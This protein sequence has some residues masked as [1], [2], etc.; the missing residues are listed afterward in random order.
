MPVEDTEEHFED[1]LGAALHQAG[2]TYETDRRTLITAGEVRGRRLLVRR[3]ASVL[4]GVAGIALVGLGGALLLPGDGDDGRRTVVASPAASGTTSA[5]PGTV[6]GDE[7]VRTLQELLPEGEFSGQQSRGTDAELPPYALTVY[8]DGQGKAAVS[9]SLSRIPQGSEQDLQ[10][11]ACPDKNLTPYDSCVTSQLPDGSALMLFQGYEYPDRR[12]DTKRWSADLVT[13]QGQHVTVTE[14]NSAAEKD[15]PISRPEP[16]LS[17]AQLKTVVTDTAWLTAIDAIPED[18]KKPTDTLEQPPAG[19]DGAAIR[20]TL[21]SLLPEDVEVVSEG[22]QETEYAYL[23][24][25]DGQGESLVQINVQPDMSDVEDEL[26]GPDAETLPDG[27]KVVT[28]QGPGEKAGAGVVMWTADTIRTDGR[29]VVISAFNS[30][31]QNEAATRDTPAL[32]IEELKDI[33]TSA[34][35]LELA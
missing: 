6:S 24:V 13:P 18:P 4:G 34:K 16:P 3:K 33:A 31:S 26:F 17:T 22:G 5:Q 15:A 29:R 19:I 1:R 27:T 20:S 9:V 23:V 25:D 30:G 11:V 32:T 2:G 21:T 28:R 8:D 7:L 14:W 10:A 12:V 35:W